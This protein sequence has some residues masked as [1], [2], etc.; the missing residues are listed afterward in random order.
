MCTLVTPVERWLQRYRNAHQET[1]GVGV[2]CVCV[3]CVV[4]NA[5]LDAM[6]EINLLLDAEVLVAFC[7]EHK[8]AVQEMPLKKKKPLKK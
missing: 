5:R 8:A 7:G 2:C 3:C 1:S 6:H 4:R